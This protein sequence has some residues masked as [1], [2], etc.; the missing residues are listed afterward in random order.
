ML[1]TS[2]IRVCD[3]DK[4]RAG[5]PLAANANGVDLVL[6]RTAAGVRAFE[7]RCP[8]QGALL[9]EG[10]I[11]GDKLV[12][13]NH[14]WRYSVNDGARDGGPQCLASYPVVERE[15]GIFVDV[16]AA[17]GRTARIAAKRTLKDLPGPRQLPWIGNLHQLDPT[18][19]HL[20]L[21]GWA[22]KY[23]P[24]FLYRLGARRVVAISDPTLGAQVLRARPETFARFTGIGPIFGEMGVEGV[25]S[26]DG[27]AWR[28]QRKLATAALAQRNVRALYPKLQM[29]L[30]RLK[31]RWEAMADAGTTLEV[32]DEIKRFTVDI[33]TLITFGYDV[34]T[35]EHGD[36]VIQ[37]KLELV[38][39]ALS[40]RLFLPFPYWRFVRLPSDRRLDRAVADLRAWMGELVA[41]ERA[42]LAAARAPERPATFLE[43]ML[44]ARD[45]AGRPFPDEV[46]FG[47]LMTMLA[48]GEDTTANTLTWTVHHVCDHPEWAAAMR[49]EADALL[50]DA[51]VA[52][53]LDVATRLNV[54][55]AVADEAMRLRPVAPLLVHFAKKETVIGDLLVPEGTG[56]AV[57]T[58]PAAVKPAHFD[59]PDG[60]RPERWL[61][62]T[63]GAHETSALMPFGSGPRICPGRVH[64]LLEMKLLLSMLYK[65]FDVERVGAAGQVR[66]HFA[67]AMAPVGVKARLRRR[68][69]T[70]EVAPARRVAAG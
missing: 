13:R 68:T 19:I 48:A 54:A 29:V 47:N 46:I 12:C 7:G 59:S 9:G 25:F 10:E 39:P 62:E 31:R 4:L 22:A 36:D 5:E 1:M 70:E 2:P 17:A 27:E 28:T 57:L 53:D 49:R 67:F 20:I 35:V 45:D 26:V 18:R 52:A 50:A 40:R 3:R 65:N 34:N 56:V 41:A 11:V 51:D 61:G 30:A 42:R 33:A 63:T 64:A 38:F 69:R 66:E 15:G 60:F 24:M 43:A 44:T 37:K 55:G 32:V 58:R 23:G 21:E 16:S 14:R 6:L 8:H